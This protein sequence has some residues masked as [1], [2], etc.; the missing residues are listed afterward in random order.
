[1]LYDS[2]R[3]YDLLFAER[4]DDVRWYTAVAGV[5]T[6]VLELGV[7]TGRIALPD[8]GEATLAGLVALARRV[9]QGVPENPLVPFYLRET[10]AEVNFPHAAAH[11]SEAL[12]KGM[13]R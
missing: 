1:M 7:G 2:P 4:E 11:L 9:S 10:D 8:E 6:E 12:R 5:P 13:A 3:M